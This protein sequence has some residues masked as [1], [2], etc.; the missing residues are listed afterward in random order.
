MRAYVAKLTKLSRK[1]DSWK[2]TAR[3]ARRLRRL[4]QVICAE[5][6]APL[7]KVQGEVLS[8][9][10]TAPVQDADLAELDAALRSSEF[11]A[12]IGVLD[13]ITRQGAAFDERKQTEARN[14]LE[15]AIPVVQA[16]AS[17][18]AVSASLAPLHAPAWGALS[19]EPDAT[20]LVRGAS[21]ITRVDP[22]THLATA[23]SPGP[24]DAPWPTLVSSSDGSQ[25]LARVF[26]RCDGSPLQAQLEPIGSS[27]GASR[28][29]P[30][31]IES[32]VGRACA[33]YPAGPA[34]D[35]RVLAWGTAGLSCLSMPFPFPLRP[36]FDGNNR[37]GHLRSGCL[38]WQSHADRTGV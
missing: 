32:S 2:D 34:A 19:F 30:L 27:G 16:A 12:A 4:R 33:R 8:C 3:G 24:A 28:V 29:V 21:A 10:A 1:K 36:I 11:V 7:V 22:K 15:H 35:A 23:A 20:L 26:D 13:R 17:A 5:G 25:R 14:R 9:G 6:G 31:P 38:A 18:L 37:R